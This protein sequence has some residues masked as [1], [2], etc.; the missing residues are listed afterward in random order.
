MFQGL[1]VAIVTPF[2][3]DFSLDEKSFADLVEFQIQ[4][5]VDGIVVAG[6]TGESPTFTDSEFVRLLEITKEVSAGRSQLIA[7]TGSN[8]FHH[9]LE[10]SHLAEKVGVDGLLVV[11]PYYN[12]P[13]QRSLLAHYNAIADNVNTPIVVYNVPGRTSVNILPETVAKMAQHTNIVAVKEACNNMGQIMDVI[14]AV[15]SGFK[16]LS[17][18]DALTLPIVAA[19][20]HG[21]VSVASNQVPHLMKSYVD[22][23][24]SG[25]SD[26]AKDLHYKLL[27]LM[28]ANF[29]ESN[30]LAVKASLSYMKKCKNV[31]RLP[32]TPLDEKFAPGLRTILS[33]L[34]VL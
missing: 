3:E 12:K 9:V 31:L 27:P 2:N 23:C 26:E 14:A 19:G 33:D 13:E 34:G 6:T 25:N 10:R 5:G 20:G 22:A 32:L 7:G 28:K 30:P 16:V 15:P 4:G 1:Y 24:I 8:N 17:G 21:L 18:D 29:W 11:A